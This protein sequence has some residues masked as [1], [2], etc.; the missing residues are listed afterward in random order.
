[1]AAERSTWYAFVI[2]LVRNGFFRLITGGL[3]AEGEENIPR[4][5]GIIFAPNHLSNLDPPA[6]ACGTNNRQLAFMA[7]E[8]LFKGLFGRLIS[9]VGAFPVRRGESDTEAIRK[10]L[11]L[12]QH[13]R[14]VLV[15]P[16]GTRGDG[17]KMGPFNRGVA[18]LAKRSAAAVLPIGVIGTHIVAPK[19]GKGLKRHRITV[20]YG[21]PFTYEEIA[22]GADEKENREFFARELE[23]RIIALCAAH[24]LQL[25]SAGSDSLQP[26]HPDPERS[27]EP[28][29][30]S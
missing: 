17:K 13:G 2:R 6:V 20:A 23:S 22:K 1:M 9:S 4:T 7:K 19:G 28:Q 11:S 3:R 29:A 10:A 5:G 15:F 8:E 14:A 26:L 25:K 18:M 24:G 30:H 21:K 27:A 16:E 12:L